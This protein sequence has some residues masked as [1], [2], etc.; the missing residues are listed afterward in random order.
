MYFNS[1]VAF[2]KKQQQKNFLPQVNIRFLLGFFFCVCVFFL[3]D[4]HLYSLNDIKILYVLEHYK[5]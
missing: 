5:S 4:A 1:T 3:L 2:E